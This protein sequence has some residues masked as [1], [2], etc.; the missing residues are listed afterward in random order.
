MLNP[1][2]IFVALSNELQNTNMAGAVI[3]DNTGVAIKVTASGHEVNT[4]WPHSGYYA[5]CDVQDYDILDA[6]KTSKRTL[7]RSGY[8]K[9]SSI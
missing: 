7:M 1:L 6:I 2:D 9:V 8:G 3:I 4:S 5:F